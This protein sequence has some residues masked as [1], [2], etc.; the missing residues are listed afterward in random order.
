MIRPT[1]VEG[2]RGGHSEQMSFQHLKFR[3][4]GGFAGLVRG[5]DL[6]AEALP[7]IVREELNQLIAKSRLAERASAGA[8]APA[9]PRDLMR[10]DIHVTAAS[11]TLHV[12]LDD[13][14]LTGDMAELVSYLVEYSR[15]LPQE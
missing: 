1:P 6:R 3:Q 7:L 14:D 5:C 11:G 10:Y 4:S 13:R 15:P 2:N 8:I 12:Y 9:R